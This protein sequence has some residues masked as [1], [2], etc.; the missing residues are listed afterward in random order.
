MNKGIIQCT[1]LFFCD[2][3]HL[4]APAL[5]VVTVTRNTKLPIGMKPL[6][7][8]TASFGVTCLELISTHLCIFLRVIASR[9]R[10]PSLPPFLAAARSLAA[11]IFLPFLIPSWR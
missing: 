9:A 6:Y 5:F 8:D 4:P 2:M 7:C 10:R 3:R 1:R 11:G